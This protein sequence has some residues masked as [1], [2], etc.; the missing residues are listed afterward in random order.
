[1]NPKMYTLSQ[2]VYKRIHINLNVCYAFVMYGGLGYIIHVTSVMY[3]H[4]MFYSNRR[5]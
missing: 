5:Q 4:I 3:I 1:M 2:F